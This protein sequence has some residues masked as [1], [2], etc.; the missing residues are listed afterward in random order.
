MCFNFSV[1]MSKL[2]ENITRKHL[3]SAWRLVTE[4]EKESVMET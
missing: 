2:A 3:P 4:R 1:D